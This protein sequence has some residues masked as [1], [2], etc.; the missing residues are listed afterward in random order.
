MAT[1]AMNL[2][3]LADAAGLNARAV[4]F[5][6]QRGLIPAPAGLGRGRHY[7]PEHLQALNRIRDLQSG[8]YSLDAIG[9]ILEGQEVEP[10]ADM[11]APAP[12]AP[13]PALEAELW[14]KLK[15]ARGVELH[16]DATQHQPRALAL[17][18]LR[19][20]IR[21]VFLNDG[22]SNSGQPE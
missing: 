11:E 13:A 21:A 9:R 6:I 20:A 12:S 15:I 5:Y 22:D 16:F 8:G 14:T 2:I 3:E 19:D 10:V 1:D 18:A 7:G 4:R 17:V